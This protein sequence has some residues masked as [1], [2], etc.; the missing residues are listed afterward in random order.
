MLQL[1]QQATAAELKEE[2]AKI[3]IR[4]QEQSD[5]TLFQE[6]SRRE[7]QE[8]TTEQLSQ[9]MQTEVES[10]RQQ[11]VDATSLA[12][13]AQSVAQFASTTVSAYETRLGEIQHTVDQL[14]QLVI[15]ER[16]NRIKMESQL[17]TAQD[18]IGAAERRTKLLEQKNENLQKE[19]DSWNEDTPPEFT[20]NLQSVASGSGLP[21]FG[22]PVSHPSVAMSAPVS[23]PVI[24]GPQVSPILLSDPTGDTTPFGGPQGNRR[25]SF[26][27][28]FDASSGPGGNG[29]NDGN[30]G[31]IGSRTVPAQPQGTST[32]NLGIKPKEPPVFYGRA[33]EDV[34]TWVAKLSDFFYLTEATPRQ[35]VAYAATLLQEAAADWWVALLRERYG[36]RPEDFQEFAVL[37]EKRFGS[38]TRVDRARAALRDIRQGQTETVRSY[39][40]RFEALLGKLPSFDQDWA[41][42]QF[43]WGLHSRVAELV[44]I[45]GPA[46]L[47]L[48]IR[49]AEEIEWPGPL[50]QEDKQDR[51]CQI[52]IEAE[53]GAN[54]YVGD[55]MQCKQ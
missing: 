37:L 31:T 6:Q 23:M 28:V 27:S 50:P 29:N 11:A 47:H 44:T 3:G 55:L 52:R 54:K 25:V 14:Q 46:D 17:S 43:I 48:A 18:K 9:W 4:I 16:K 41:K 39:S 10:T 32:F 8:R 24:G 45:A 33:N 13:Q 7:Q 20:S 49:K 1:T 36:L 53:A 15:D 12:I 22:M 19:L 2:V 5:R 35:Q 42:T 51:R 30:S 21:H 38:S 40:T 26:G 34:T